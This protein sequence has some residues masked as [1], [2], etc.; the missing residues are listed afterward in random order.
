MQDI[1]QHIEQIIAKQLDGTLNAEEQK[2]LQQWLE[3]STEHSKL[4]EET[5]QIWFQ[6]QKVDVDSAWEKVSA[7]ID[8]KESAVKVFSIRPWLSRAAVILA[9]CLIS[10]VT[11]LL[12]NQSNENLVAVK[13]ESEVQELKLSDSSQISLNIGTTLE[14]PEE[15]DTKQRKVKLKGEAFFKVQHAAEKPFIIDASAV[16]VEVLGTSFFVNSPEDAEEIEVG[17]KSG[18]VSVTSKKTGEQRILTKGEKLTYL[19][20]KSEFVLEKVE[21]DD[22]LWQ[23]SA[24]LY[25]QVYLAEVFSDLEE[26]FE[27]KIDYQVEDFTNCQFSGRFNTKSEEDILEQISLSFGFEFEK[28]EQGYQLKGKPKC[29]K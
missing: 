12:F 18:R 23:D 26:Q 20:A 29:Q 10:A 3:E 2:V 8:Q 9:I 22:L 21:A 14:Y 16:D 1:P 11:Y 5:Q 24:L 15:F 6:A 7:Q 19:V 25:N 17:V 4:Y 28:T 27:I 13:A